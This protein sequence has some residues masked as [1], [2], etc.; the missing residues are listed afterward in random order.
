[1]YHSKMEYRNGCGENIA[2]HSDTKLISTTNQATQMWYDEVTKPGYDF[3]N[4]GFSMATGH[5]TKVV[6]KSSTELGCGVAG[7]YVVCQYCKEGGNML[8][9]FEKNVFPKGP[10]AT[11]LG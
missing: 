1:M 10:E 8:G 4:Q 3:K 11:C 7:P 9:I 6:W 2:M 5:F